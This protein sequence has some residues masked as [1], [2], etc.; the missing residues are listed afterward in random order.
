MS[1]IVT[2]STADLSRHETSD[3]EAA[4]RA[5][6]HSTA[7]VTPVAWQSSEHRVDH[8][9]P[10]IIGMSD[11]ALAHALAL[12]LSGAGLPAVLDIGQQGAP[13]VVAVDLPHHRR[14]SVRKLTM[15][16]ATA[17]D[18]ASHRINVSATRGTSVRVSA[19]GAAAAPD[20]QLSLPLRSSI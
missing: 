2:S 7:D 9:R 19:P 20:N 6:S 14:R 13:A 3:G 8:R 17:I 11:L 4:S 15:A 16:A 12:A 5:E 1:L 10:L 18:P